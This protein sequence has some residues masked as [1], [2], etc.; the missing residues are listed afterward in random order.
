MTSSL[1]PILPAVYDVLFNFAQSDG[2]W[3]NLVTAFGTSYD[4]VKATQL[5]QQ[6]QSRNFSQIPPI[7]VLSD[8]VLGT[9]NGAYSSSTNKIYLSASFLNTASS[10]AIINV[11]LEEIGHYVDAQI[12]QVDSAGDEGA[13]FAE[14]VQGNSLDV[15]TLDA[16]RA[17]NDQTTI[18]V[19]GEIIQVEQ[20][21]FTG[22]NGNDN[23]TGTSGD[24]RI[25]G[26]D[27]NDT[28]SGLG[29]DDKIYG[30]NGNDSLDGGDGYDYFTNDA[31]NDTI[32]GGSGTD[33]YE[34]D[35]SSASSGLTMT[36]N[37]TTGSGTITVGTE[38]DTFTSIESFGGFNGTEYNDVIFGGTAS[39]YDYG[40]LAGG[41]G[42]D[43]ISGNAGSDYIYGEDGNDVLNGGADNDQLYG[44]SGNDSLNGDAGNDYFTNDA[45]NDTINGGSEI[46]H[47]KADY[48]SASSGLT[49]TY[50]TATGSGTITVGAETD[51]FTSI[52]SFGGFKGTEYNDVIF[53]GTVSEQ[54][55]NGFGYGQLE[56]GGGNDTISGNAGDDQIY[57]EDGNDVLN[58]GDG[59]D[60][61]FGGNGN[62]VLNGDLGNDKF[63]N[64]AGNDTING[65]AGSDIYEA[66]YSYASSGLTMTY[67]T[68][69][70]SGTIT[71]GTETDTFTSIESFGQ[72]SPFKGTEYNDVIF[73]GIEGDRLSGG[74]GNDTI[75]GNAGNDEIY[76]DDG[77][78]VLNGGAGYDD[79]RGGNGNDTLQGTNSGIGESD[80]LRGGTENDLF[81]LGDT[82]RVFY[83][84]GFSTTG[85]TSDYAIIYDF[86]P[87]D[88]TIQL[89]GSSSD[90]LLTV[91]S[92]ITNLYINKPGT[93][94][95]ELI[96]YITDQT[97]LSLTASYFSYVSSP[98]LPSITLAVSPASV[99]E[100]GTANLI[101]TFTRTG[102]T[103]S[104]LTAN[105]TVGGTATFS[106]DY[107]QTGAASFTSTTGTVNF[108]ANS[109]TATV[110]VDPTADTTVE[111]NE[112]VILTLAAGTGYTV[113]TTTAVTGTITN[114]PATSVTPIEAFGNTK[115]VQDAT[116]KLYAQI[117][118]N[119]PTVIK[120]GATHIT[121][122][123][124][125]GWQ[126]L[127]AETVNGIN[128]VLLRNTSQNL[129]YIWNLD[130]NWNWQS[131][132]G[133]WGLNSTQAF[134][135][136][137]NFKQDF[138]GDGFIGQ[139][140][141]PIETFGNTKL[142]Q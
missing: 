112:T 83:D 17:E 47:Y 135:Q 128:Q 110:T 86:N 61:L 56:G 53:G 74:R 33:R 103:T 140:F 36:Y 97:A 107:T 20:A 127:A 125:P 37:T 95:D 118:N 91:S 12:N 57:G 32:N 67:D 120:N 54:L 126:I 35:Y 89:R 101:Y 58:G 81:I 82:T 8:E 43:T 40:G 133:G 7:E 77:N 84:D 49:M 109:P 41:G 72:T 129:L 122:N 28:L 79:L 142:V 46:D 71:V 1:L 23:I 108:L 73:G 15:A 59:K 5:R 11:I 64:D 19:N 34:V 78:D 6:W 60:S 69:T 21:N 93:E 22:T 87:T 138:N 102:S 80:A 4:V 105:Y 3:A 29:G 26:L 115:L 31:G 27:G 48:S 50:N 131:S 111:S 18:I 106:T 141:T 42:N 16:L 139:P 30:G 75:S 66:D 38:T 99:T 55:F 51:S 124:Y 98:T 68:A 94:P 136:E 62:D 76:G 116:N 90:Y 14:L 96:A 119:N 2:F 65:G 123:T 13:I 24:D 100:D 134:N 70:A 114:V 132:T 25:Y 39:E 52:E 85:G 137:T 9:A 117:G 45:G 88:D 44:G 63:T 10:A 104:A 121:T 113:G 92:S 130:S